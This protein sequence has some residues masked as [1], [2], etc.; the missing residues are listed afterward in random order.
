MVPREFGRAFGFD[1]QHTHDKKAITSPPPIIT[2]RSGKIP[3]S[4]ISQ[5]MPQSN[6][7]PTEPPTDTPDSDEDTYENEQHTTPTPIR[8]RPSADTRAQPERIPQPPR[9]SS[10]SLM[11][12]L[13]AQNMQTMESNRQMMQAFMQTMERMT[14]SRR[15]S[16]SP[17]HPQPIANPY[18]N[19]RQ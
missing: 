15:A 9:A 17:P 4:P 11:D 19:T 13:I 18:D 12:A 1:N 2:R 7:Q 3:R 10:P 14:P 5:S 8:K 16:P 6:E